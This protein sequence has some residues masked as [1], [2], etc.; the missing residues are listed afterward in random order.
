MK[1]VLQNEKF[2][3]RV[4]NSSPGSESASRLEPNSHEFWA[5]IPRKTLDRSVI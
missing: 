1:L 4:Q 2:Q 5:S 3:E